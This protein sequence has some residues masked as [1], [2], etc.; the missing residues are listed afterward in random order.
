MYVLSGSIPIK[1]RQLNGI[2]NVSGAAYSSRGYEDWYIYYFKLTENTLLINES[3]QRIIRYKTG[4]KFSK[5]SAR[6][7]FPIG[8]YGCRY[9]FILSK[10]TFQSSMEF[11]I[12]I[13]WLFP[14][15]TETDRIIHSASRL[16]VE[17]FRFHGYPMVPQIQC[18]FTTSALHKLHRRFGHP[19]ADTLSN[20]P[21]RTGL[22]N[23]PA[24]PVPH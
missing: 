2:I 18:I 24:T 10:H 22:H 20:V 7:D 11:K 12:W 13:I 8:I 1:H 3:Q 5:V 15:I 9:K 23:S 14:S 17:P 6:I 4:K 19:S 21:N 16:S